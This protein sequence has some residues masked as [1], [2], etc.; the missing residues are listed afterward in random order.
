MSR[1]SLYDYEHQQYFVPPRYLDTPNPTGKMLA[2]DFS[3]KPI[4]VSAIDTFQYFIIGSE[5]ATPISE[6]GVTTRNPAWNNGGWY[7]IDSIRRLEVYR[8]SSSGSLSLSLQMYI[9]GGWG[10][11]V[12]GMTLTKALYNVD[13]GDVLYVSFDKHF[14]TNY[15]N[16]NG[17]WTTRFTVYVVHQDGSVWIN[18]TINAG[19]YFFDG[20]KTADLPD[21]EPETAV[22]NLDNSSDPIAF[23]ELPSIDI[24]DTG[25]IRAYKM[26]TNDLSSLAN[27]LWS[28]DFIDAIKAFFTSPSEAIV[29]L[30]V[31]PYE[32]DIAGQAAVKIGNFTSSIVASRIS[33]QYKI[34]DFGA[35]Q[36][37]EYFGGYQ[38]YKTRISIYLPFI[39][40][41]ELNAVDVMGATIHLRYYVDCVSG[42]TTA[43]LKV[44][45]RNTDSVLYSWS[46]STIMSI[47]ISATNYAEKAK[48]LVSGVLGIAANVA[49]TIAT[50][51]VTA[52]AVIAGVSGVGG[53]ASSQTTHYTRVSNVSGDPSFM[54][55]LQPYITIT[56]PRMAKP[57]SYN[58]NIGR[59]SY[60][61]TTIGSLS[62][63]T[64]IQAIHIESI[65]A[66]DSERSEI[67][68]LLK[69]GVII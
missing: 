62:G 35:I 22:G 59:P 20:L 60:I 47:P 2:D 15:T 69:E 66:T 64:Q 10:V 48:G 12:S 5:G 25:I 6:N 23:P 41:Q 14:A 45:K 37:A 24:L 3:R 28:P 31:I 9:D 46:G 32:P 26:S 50:G 54:G 30:H 52:P 13:A 56:R 36:L 61:T 55:V 63:L 11:V 58:N 49:G 43:L 68:S 16:P 44:S 33:N 34:I 42:V 7:F 39:G 38:D 18:N 1:Y 67:E 21:S 4:T 53:L 51:G 27:I 57:E 40:N 19:T 65:N 8:S 29:S 17:M